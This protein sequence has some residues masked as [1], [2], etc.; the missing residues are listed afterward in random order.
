[1]YNIYF[2]SIPAAPCLHGSF[3]GHSKTGIYAGTYVPVLLSPILL[4]K[5]LRI[6]IWR[7]C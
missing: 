3:P 4:Y 1:M 7:R 2:D 6:E 5:R